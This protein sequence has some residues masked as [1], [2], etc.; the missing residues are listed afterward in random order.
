MR[1]LTIAAELDADPLRAARNLRPYERLVAE[2]AAVAYET[3][4]DFAVTVSL[5]TARPVD[6]EDA[7][8][9]ASE[10]KCVQRQFETRRGEISRTAANSSGVSQPAKPPRHTASSSCP[11]LRRCFLDHRCAAHPSSTSVSEGLSAGFELL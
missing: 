9:S 10:A 11:P 6:K 8:P 4:F 7:P 5:H 2:P 3:P 1:L